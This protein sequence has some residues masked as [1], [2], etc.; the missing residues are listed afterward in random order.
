VTSGVPQGSVCGP[1]LFLAYVSNIDEELNPE[2]GRALF[3]DD[4]KIFHPNGS[5][6]QDS[7]DKILKWSSNWQLPLNTTKLELLSIGHV[8]E[9]TEIRIAGDCVPISST[10]RDLGV[11]MDSGLSFKDHVHKITIEGYR[12]ANFLLRRFK[13]LD[14]AF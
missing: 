2:V 8:G 14:L 4:L 10:V 1:F 12:R 7:A 11:T 3:A 9:S 5:V 13:H 6:L